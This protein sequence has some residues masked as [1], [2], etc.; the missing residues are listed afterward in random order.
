MKYQI[1]IK[2]ITLF[3]FCFCSGN[4]IN[5][6]NSIENI[7]CHKGKYQSP[8]SITR[9]NS[10]FLYSL[11][12]V[13]EIYYISN[14]I[15]NEETDHSLISSNETTF[16]FLIFNNNKVYKQYELIKFEIYKGLHEINGKISDY[17]LHLV[18]KKNLG[19]QSKPYS[20]QII[21]DPNNY[22]V[23]VLRYNSTTNNIENNY[24]YDNNLLKD[25]FSNNKINFG[26]YN[27]I[28]GKNSKTLIKILAQLTKELFLEIL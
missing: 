18:Y 9:D 20:N 5:S 26:I 2:I 16:G 22:L 11:G 17:E 21:T 15:I 27:L 12:I 8:I 14:Y 1:I 7:I 28:D 3:L 25:I 23:I 19:Y 10:K 13:N 24:S 4:D 6:D